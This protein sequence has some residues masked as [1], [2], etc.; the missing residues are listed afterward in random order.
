MST[1]SNN[2]TTSTGIADSSW[3]GYQNDAGK[4]SQSMY[5]GPQTNTTKWTYNNITVYGSA[6]TGKNGNVH[7]AGDDGILYT[8]NST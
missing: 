7:V 1:A 4:T 6:V 3:P 2:T 8:F 5:I